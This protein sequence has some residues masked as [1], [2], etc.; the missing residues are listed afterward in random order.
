MLGYLVRGSFVEDDQILSKEVPVPFYTRKQQTVLEFVAEYQRENGISPTLEEIGQHLGVTRVTAFQHVKS[1]IDKRAVRTSPLLSRSI[2]ILDP[3]Y[4]PEGEALPILGRIAAGS[5]IEAIEVHEEFDPR[6][7]FPSG[8]GYFLLRVKGDS[9]IGD[10]IADGDLVLV[11]P[12]QSAGDGDTVVAVLPDGDAT[13]KRLYKEE[14]R[15]RLQPS[16]PTM[17]PI[18]TDELEVRGVVRGVLRRY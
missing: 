13:L 11:E 15:F 1:L 9:M 4:R 5:P 2:E 18:Y 3:D 12:R 8:E 16:N 6:E 7:F 17:N 14:G 10:Q